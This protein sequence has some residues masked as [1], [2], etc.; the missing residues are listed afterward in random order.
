MKQNDNI[1]EILKSVQ[2][3]NGHAHLFPDEIRTLN[4]SGSNATGCLW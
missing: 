2:N 3:I 4:F 1:T